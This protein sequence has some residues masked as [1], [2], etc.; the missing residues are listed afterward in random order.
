MAK[1][2]RNVILLA[3]IQPAAGTDSVPTAAANAILCSEPK[4]DPLNAQIVKR[5][6]VMAWMGNPGSIVT[7]VYATIE[8]EVELQGS[9]TAGTAPKFGPLLRGCAL[10]ET[11]VALTSVAYAPVDTAHEFLSFYYFLDGIKHVVTD[12]KGTVSFDLNAL[13]IPVMKFKFWGFYSTPT[14]IAN[15]SGSDYSGFKDPLPVS[16]TNTTTFT[17]HGIVVKSNSQSLDLANQVEYINKP[18]FEGIAIINRMPVGSAVFEVDTLAVKDWYSAIKAG[19]LGA[20]AVTH[21]VG[22]GSITS[23]AAPKVQLT[24]LTYST[25]QGIAHCNSGMELKANAGR[26]ELVLTFT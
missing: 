16:K 15:P 20:L 26:D 11:I 22:A 8:F 25:V 6:N 1:T 9:G 23:M 4:V 7:A 19:T 14:D 3:K 21:G 2:S 24:G 5:N 10:G 17:L 18:N 13:G 12:A